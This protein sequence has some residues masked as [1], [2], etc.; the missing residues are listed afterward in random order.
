MDS[1]AART[2]N[3]NILV[4]HVFKLLTIFVSK[5]VYISDLFE[6]GKSYIV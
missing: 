2:S 6:Q 3:V 4:W 5:Y 1:R